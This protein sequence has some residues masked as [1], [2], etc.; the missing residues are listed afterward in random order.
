MRVLA[1]DYGK[2]RM[3][4]AVSD[5]LGLTAQPLTTIER[6]GFK[7]DSRIIEELCREREVEELVVGLPVRMD[8]T[9]G[10]E[11]EAVMRFVDKLQEFLGLPIHTWDERLSTVAAERVL[12]EA[13]L[14]RRKRK[15]VVDR[16]AAAWILQAWLDRRHREIAEQSS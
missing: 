3:G 8:G 15:K 10:P 4:V 14:S 16:V 13:D 5:G 12:I 2:K 11:V 6:K 7:T 1:L 9:M